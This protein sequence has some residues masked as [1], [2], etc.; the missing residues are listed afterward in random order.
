M[1]I[2][3]EEGGA[4]YEAGLQDGDTIIG[5]KL[6]DMEEFIVIN[7]FNDL[8][9]AILNSK[10]GDEIIIKYIRNGEELISHSTM[11]DVHPD[12]K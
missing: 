7:N 9:E 10:V 5:Y 11:L 8:K 3:V 12:D 6:I 2:S 4:A 1:C